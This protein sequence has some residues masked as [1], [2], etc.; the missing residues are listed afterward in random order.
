VLGFGFGLWFVAA[1]R[2]KQSY[3]KY[4]SSQGVMKALGYSHG[5]NTK[6]DNIALDSAAQFTSTINMQHT[7]RHKRAGTHSH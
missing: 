1:R 5:S 4:E 3:P 7:D 6:L 2:G